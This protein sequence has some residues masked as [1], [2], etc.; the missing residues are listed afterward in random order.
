MN[1]IYERFIVAFIIYCLTQYIIFNL[2]RPV[3]GFS[4]LN[5]IFSAFVGFTVF[6]YLDNE[7]KTPRRIKK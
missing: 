6:L 3:I 7:P 2:F 4:L 5:N 1:S